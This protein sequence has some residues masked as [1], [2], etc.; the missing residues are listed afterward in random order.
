MTV[1]EQDANP[2]ET[3][4]ELLLLRAHTTRDFAE[5]WLIRGDESE[6]YD[7]IVIGS[8]MG[9][10]ILADSL[11]DMGVRV[12]VLEAG[13]VNYVENVYNLPVGKNLDSIDTYVNE[14]NSKLNL[15]AC[16]NFGGRSIYWSAVIPRM[17]TFDLKKW[18]MTIQKYLTADGYSR[19]ETLMRKRGTFSDFESGMVH[20][21]RSVFHDYF[22][23]HT[24]RSYYFN[25]SDSRRPGHPDEVPSGIFST[26]AL[27]LSHFVNAPTNDSLLKV[28]L[29]TL[30]VSVEHSG[31]TVTA[32]NCKDVRSGQDRRYKARYIVLAA[33][34]TESPCIC[35]TSNLRDQSGL[36]GK[37]LT[38]H[39]SSEF[40]FSLP[41]DSPLVG[42]NDM[43][44]A[45]M[46]PK[47]AA[48]PDTNFSCELALNYKFWDVR[49]DDDEQWYEK[50]G[51][52]TTT[53]STIKFL[54]SRDLNNNNWIRPA[55]DAKHRVMVQVMPER[56]LESES[57]ALIE[58][59]LRY[60]GI[61]EQCASAA[62]EYRNESD[63]PHCG[64]SLRVG[65]RRTSVVD[66]D[67]RF[68][69]YDN[70]FCC[71]NSIAPHIATANP[72]LTLAALAL[73]LAAH[74]ASDL[75]R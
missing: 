54:Y 73:R 3:S 40:H 37:G 71:D 9:G 11:A 72:S 60:L 69:E 63:T 52:D 36:I 21:L 20:E 30:A 55:P 51:K 26:A 46:R 8:G 5:K 7:V 70:L 56:P 44:R 33:G 38:D 22:V 45:L 59:I 2:G 34:A 61:E 41:F 23:D 13:G 28:N 67:L 39:Q 15:G 64:G 14:P 48:H 17:S 6:T 75:T 1:A 25:A 74:L 10:G 66:S 32:V 57:W 19:A 4:S 42:P 65:E 16:I 24:P 53:A 47:L 18:P 31:S 35:L 27:L 43:I 58:K 68:H 12:L 29:Q 49:Y 50:F 62:L